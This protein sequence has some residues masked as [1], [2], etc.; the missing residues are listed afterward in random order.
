MSADRV[1]I[2]NSFYAIWQF[3]P[4]VRMKSGVRS[5]EIGDTGSDSRARGVLKGLGNKDT[6]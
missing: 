2:A 4:A 1:R 5:K 3:H 6:E